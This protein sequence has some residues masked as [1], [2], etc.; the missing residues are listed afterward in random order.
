MTKNKREKGRPRRFETPQ[1]FYEAFEHY[2]QWVKDNPIYVQEAIKGG[3]SSGEIVSIKRDRPLTFSGF[4]VFMF[5][6]YNFTGTRHYLYNQTGAYDDFLQISNIIRKEIREEQVTGGMIG[7]YNPSLT[8]RL[9]NLG[10]K[11][12]LEGGNEPIKVTGMRII[13]SK[14]D[15]TD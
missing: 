10:E 14:E 5:R 6:E 11:H 4:E 7:M 12:I 1:E 3:R 8:A 9:N 13:N 2:K 15:E